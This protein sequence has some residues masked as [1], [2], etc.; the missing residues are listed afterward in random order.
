M[1]IANALLKEGLEEGTAIATGIKLARN[2]LKLIEA[3]ALK[4]SR[5]HTNLSAGA[6]L[7][8]TM[9]KILFYDKYYP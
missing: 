1:E 3:G 9:F 8:G 2:I 4:T 5:M 6:A 7:R